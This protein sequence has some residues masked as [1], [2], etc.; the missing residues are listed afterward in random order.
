MQMGGLS[1]TFGKQVGTYEGRT[2]RAHQFLDLLKS[3][4]AEVVAAL[5]ELQRIEGCDEPLLLSDLSENL[6][7]VR[8]LAIDQG[9]FFRFLERLSWHLAYESGEP[10]EREEGK[11]KLLE[12]IEYDRVNYGAKRVLKSKSSVEQLVATVVAR[13]E[14]TEK[15]QLTQRQKHPNIRLLNWVPILIHEMDAFEYILY[16]LYWNAVRWSSGQE[17]FALQLALDGRR[18]SLT[19]TLFND[20]S[21]E[22][23][24]TGQR[25]KCICKTCQ[26]CASDYPEVSFFR[27]PK[28]TSVYFFCEACLRGEWSERLEKCYEPGVSQGTSGMGLFLVKYYIEVGFGGSPF[29]P[30]KIMDE[31]FWNSGKRKRVGFGFK[32]PRGEFSWQPAQEAKTRV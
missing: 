24:K 27:E 16:E 26:K 20:L 17:R 15:R 13:I 30:E 12:K 14:A 18:E 3:D 22:R 6:E 19:V 8:G 29:L 5:R 10:Q 11:K 28:S 2:Q 21:I 31:S 32:M 9:K 1:H 7:I 25:P 4:S 23:V